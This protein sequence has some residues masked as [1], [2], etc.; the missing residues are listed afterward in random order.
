MLLSS[1]CLLLFC[2]SPGWKEAATGGVAFFL[3]YIENV[4]LSPSFPGK[5]LSSI[6]TSFYHYTTEYAFLLSC[7]SSGLMKNALGAFLSNF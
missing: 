3:L 4:F 5:I 2:H 7:S 6:H 1:R